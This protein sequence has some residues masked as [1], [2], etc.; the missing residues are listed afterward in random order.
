MARARKAGTWRTSASTS[1]SSSGRSSTRSSASL[2]LPGMTVTWSVTGR[3]GRLPRA[4]VQTRTTRR[5]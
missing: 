4:S 1:T 3:P 2:K 5:G